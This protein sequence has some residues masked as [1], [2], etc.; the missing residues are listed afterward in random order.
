VLQLVRIYTT[1][2]CLLPSIQ[3]RLPWPCRRGGVKT[4]MVETANRSAEAPARPQQARPVSLDRLSVTAQ[5]RAPEQLSVRT[6]L[7][8]VHKP[9]HCHV[10][11]PCRA[12]TSHSQ[13]M[14]TRDSRSATTLAI[15]TLLL[16][17]ARSRLDQCCANHAPSLSERPE[18]PPQPSCFVPFRRDPD[19]VARATL[20]D[21]IRERCAVPASRVALVGL[22]GVGYVLW[23]E[24]WSK[25]TPRF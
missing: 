23:K 9:R 18:T 12:P 5:P 13:G 7:S 15:S 20:L 1:F 14:A 11:W 22:G 10:R 4:M 24:H 19:F 8:L 3:D 25:L 21:Q 16:A 6:R 2:S 17:S